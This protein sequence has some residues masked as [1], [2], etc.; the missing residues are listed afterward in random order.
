M[1]ERE[2]QTSDDLSLPRN[3]IFVRKVFAFCAQLLMT[4]FE[5]YKIA[6]WIATHCFATEKIPLVF[7]NTIIVQ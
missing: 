4:M 6:L 2:K 1:K 3:N 7:T 5:V